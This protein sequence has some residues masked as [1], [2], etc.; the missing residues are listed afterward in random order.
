MNTA[1]VLDCEFSLA[2]ECCYCVF[3]DGEIGILNME[4]R[5][6]EPLF[7]PVA[8]SPVTDMERGSFQMDPTVYASGSRADA[9][10]LENISRVEAD[11]DAM[12]T[13]NLK[14]IKV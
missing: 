14:K 12:L 2:P 1:A 6:I 3:P 10:R 7:L 4:T 5:E 9:K 8:G 13:E 11:M